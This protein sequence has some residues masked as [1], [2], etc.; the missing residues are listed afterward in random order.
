MI[1]EFVPY[2][3]R[4]E[5]LLSLYDVPGAPR[6]GETC[7][8]QLEPG[9]PYLEYVIEDVEWQVTARRPDELSVIAIVRR[10]TGFDA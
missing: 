9:E 8:L 1:L 3:D 10:K 4:D 5:V 7:Y 6:R 2:E